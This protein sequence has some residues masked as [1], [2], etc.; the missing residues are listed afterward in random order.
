MQRVIQSTASLLQLTIIAGRRSAL[1]DFWGGQ[2]PWRRMPLTT[3]STRRLRDDEEMARKAWW[4]R[5]FRGGSE[6]VAWACSVLVG[7]WNKALGARE[8]GEIDGPVEQ[9][10]IGQRRAGL[11]PWALRS[12]W[13]QQ[14]WLGFGGEGRYRVGLQ[15]QRARART[16]IDTGGIDLAWERRDTPSTA[17]ERARAHP[18][19]V[20]VTSTKLGC[21]NSAA[22]A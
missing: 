22:G 18:A 4:E 16:H 19:G 12:A 1:L 13:M 2:A 6:R 20:C 15:V 10:W 21:S 14:R 8:R 11:C 17:A 3:K 9:T 7:R 5:A